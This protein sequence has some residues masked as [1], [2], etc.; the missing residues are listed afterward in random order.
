MPFSIH[1]I[2]V[3]SGVVIGQAVVDNN[4]HQPIE[5]YY[6]HPEDAHQEWQL[7][8]HARDK[9]VTELSFAI[10]GLVDK[11]EISGI[12]EMQLMLIGED[13]SLMQ[14]SKQ[15]IQNH[16]YN[17]QWALV[18]TLDEVVRQFN[19]IEDDYLRERKED[20]KQVVNKMLHYLQ[21]DHLFTSQS[22]GFTTPDLKESNPHMELILVA[23]DLLSTDIYQCRKNGFNGFVTDLGGHHSHTAIIARSMGIPAVIA[24]HNASSLIHEGDIIIVD[25]LQGVVLVNPDERTIQFYR[26][27]ILHLKL[28]EN[29]LQWLCSAPSI[30]ADGRKIELL[31]NIERP[32][33][34]QNILA[35]GAQGIGL[36]RSEF[37][38]LGRGNSLPSEDEQYQAYSQVCHIVGGLPVTIRTVDVGADKILEHSHSY[39]STGSYLG[40]RAIR[41]SLA[42]PEIFLSQLRAILRASILGNVRLLIPMLSDP[43]EAVKVLQ[44]LDLAKKQLEQRQVPYGSLLVGAM[45]EVPSLAISIHHFI[46]MFDFFSIGTN[47]LTQYTLAIDRQDE[48]VAHLYNSA[49]PA[50]IQLIHQTIKTVHKNHK[51]VTL[52]GEIAGEALWTKFLLSLGLRSFS[53][54]ERRILPIKQLIRET[55]TLT[56]EPWSTQVLASRAPIELIKRGPN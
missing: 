14:M 21:P 4:T 5:H 22:A 3:G 19:E 13:D 41:W 52:C 48:Q 56:L 23:Q 44:L 50:V 49:H 10:K 36:F 30:T 37:L 55:N 33:D 18:A 35:L 46:D 24:T 32:E 31:A 54:Q 8:L 34:A 27:K 51:W 45:V 6:I 7:L 12:L 29:N 42:E 2:A 43:E 25:S 39:Q 17:A 11:S 9:L 16:N 28:A 53:M 47:D 15:W 26:Q 38:F 20:V 1:G 40:L